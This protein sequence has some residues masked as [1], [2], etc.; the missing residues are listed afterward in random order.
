MKFLTNE[1][2]TCAINTAFL[3]SIC[4]RTNGS[5]VEI[6]AID[7][8]YCETIP[9]K[10]FSSGDRAIDET[11]AQKYLVELVDKLNDGVIL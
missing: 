2:G 11:A 1:T 10:T 9:L 8:H 4:I 3:R 7:E 6:V 5:R